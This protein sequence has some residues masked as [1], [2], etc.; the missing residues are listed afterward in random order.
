MTVG[1]GSSSKPE[2][3]KKQALKMD[4]WLDGPLKTEWQKKKSILITFVQFE[5]QD[6][7]EQNAIWPA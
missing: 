3:R 1:R 5:M 6:N 4:G 2:V 7:Y